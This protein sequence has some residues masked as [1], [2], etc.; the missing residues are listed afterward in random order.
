MGTFVVA[1]D[2]GTLL[3][4]KTDFLLKNGFEKTSQ[5]P[6]K[7]AT[8]QAPIFDIEELGDLCASCSKRSEGCHETC[9]VRIRID[10]N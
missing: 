4:H 8:N 1:P 2:I 10:F 3:T 5:R 9:E 6:I 7:D